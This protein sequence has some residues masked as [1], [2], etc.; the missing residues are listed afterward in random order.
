MGLV[1]LL[2]T[3]QRKCVLNLIPSVHV[4]MD[5]VAHRDKRGVRDSSL[6]TSQ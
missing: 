5:L 1:K 6:T 2:H 3:E 4:I